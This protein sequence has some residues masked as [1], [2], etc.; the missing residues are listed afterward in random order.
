MATVLFWDLWMTGISHWKPWAKWGGLLSFLL[1]AYLEMKQGH[2]GSGDCSPWTF[3][4]ATVEAGEYGSGLL[5]TGPLSKGCQSTAA[6]FHL[7]WNPTFIF[8]SRNVFFPFWVL[9]SH[10]HSVHTS[11][12]QWSSLGEGIVAFSDH[13]KSWLGFGLCSP[14]CNCICLPT[15]HIESCHEC[16]L[17]PF[18]I[19]PD[20]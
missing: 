5:Q 14:W 11:Y 3:N 17:L 8:I 1:L 2:G 16:K 13:S 4:P 18:Y 7:K 9:Q 15:V 20:F 10:V 6:A 12:A 19:A